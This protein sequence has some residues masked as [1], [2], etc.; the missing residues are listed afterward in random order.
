M[1]ADFYEVVETEVF[2]LPE[3]AER[4]FSPRTL[5]RRVCSHHY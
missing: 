2:P 5:A 3:A 4:D 1:L